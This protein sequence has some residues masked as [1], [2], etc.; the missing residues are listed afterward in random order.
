MFQS[1][2]GNL[3]RNTLCDY[4]CAYVGA[5]VYV[6]MQRAP[7]VNLGNNCFRHWLDI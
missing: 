6:N 2:T 7:K 4:E 1:V 5:Y 3:N